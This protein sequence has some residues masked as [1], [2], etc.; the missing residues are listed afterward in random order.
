MK[1]NLPNFNLNFYSAYIILLT[2]NIL[3]YIYIN[4][5]KKFTGSI[6]VLLVLGRRTGGHYED[7][8]MRGI[9]VTGFRKSM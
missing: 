1:T 9:T 5:N 3:I 6:K 4:K 7:C 2:A 8:Y